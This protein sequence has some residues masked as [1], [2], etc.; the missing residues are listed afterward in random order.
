MTSIAYGAFTNCNKLTVRCW[1][2]TPSHQALVQAWRGPIT[3][4]DDPLMVNKPT[5]IRVDKAP[6]SI[7]SVP[8]QIESKNLADVI[9]FKTKRYS[10]CNNE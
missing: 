2:D 8:S 9:T 1:K 7:N 6:E 4:L 5:P 10:H 3:F